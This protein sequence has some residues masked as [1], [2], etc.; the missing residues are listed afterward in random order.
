MNPLNLFLFEIHLFY[1][2]GKYGDKVTKNDIIRII[3]ML[4]N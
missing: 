2:D 1:G 4:Y 3:I